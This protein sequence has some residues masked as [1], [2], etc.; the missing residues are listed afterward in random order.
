M[1]IPLVLHVFDLMVA[2]DEKSGDNQS[3]YS[4]FCGGHE[5][6]KF[7]ASDTTAVDFSLKI[8]C[9]P[10][11]GTKGKVRRICRINP[12]GNI[13]ICT[14]FKGNQLNSHLDISIWTKVVD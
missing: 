6:Q 12:L 1:G 5:C 4:S 7:V 9:K 14:K 11:G 13:N 2:L 3:V 8:E 10:P